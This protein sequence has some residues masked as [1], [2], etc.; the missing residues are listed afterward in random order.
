[1][2]NKHDIRLGDIVV[3]APCDGNGVVLQYD[4]GKTI[5]GQTFQHTRFLNQPPTTL[6]AALTGIKAK[7]QIKGH[8]LEAAINTILKNNPRLQ[9][10][11]QRPHPDADRLFKADVVHDSRGCLELCANEPSKL[12]SRRQQTELEDNP[13]IHHGLVASANQLMKD[14]TARDRLAM[15]RDVLCFEMEAAGLMNSFPCLVIRGICDYSD[16]HKNKEWQGYAAL[17]AAA[18]AKD[19]L[20]RIAPNR[21]E[22]EKK[23]GDILGN[24]NIL[25]SYYEYI[26]IPYTGLPKVAEEHQDIAKEQLQAQKDLAKE[27]LSKEEQE[28]HQLFRLTTG[29]RDATYEW[30]KDRVEEMVADTCQWFLKNDYFEIWLKQESGP[31]LVSADPSCGK[32]VLAKYLIDHGLP[33]SATICYFFFK[34]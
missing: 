18:Y 10:K 7:Y 3:S 6:R 15:E 20:C 16:S 13:A 24:S 32:S 23:I 34:D 8:Q 27:R 1:M 19:L 5:Q 2:R 12:I 22:S 4:F 28:C 29:S 17:A 9:Q 25:E 30:Y 26:L 11:Y 21:V 31:L 14:A 33:R